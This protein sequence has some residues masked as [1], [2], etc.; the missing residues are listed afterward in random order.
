MVLIARVGGAIV[1][2]RVFDTET[3]GVAESATVTTTENAPLAVGVPEMMPVPAAIVKPAGKL[4]AD[5][6]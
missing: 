6:L 3:G 2:D 5:Q 1:K 4:V